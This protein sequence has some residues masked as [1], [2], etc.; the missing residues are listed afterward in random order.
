M[1]KNIIII[2]NYV[3]YKWLFI[4]I[5][6]HTFKRNFYTNGICMCK[7]AGVRITFIQNNP[8]FSV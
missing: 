7:Q 8:K 2:R 3:V 5:I 4:T 1:Y 6:N